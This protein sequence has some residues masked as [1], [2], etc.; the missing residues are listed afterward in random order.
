MNPKSRCPPE[1]S[2]GLTGSTG[3][4]ATLLVVDDD[5]ELLGLE[6]RFLGGLGYHVL[7]AS[8]PKEAL[9]LAAIT[10]AIDLLLTDYSM[11]ETNGLELARL[12]RSV[13]PKAPVLMVSGSLEMLNGDA[14]GLERFETLAKPFTVLELVQKVRT[15]LDGVQSHPL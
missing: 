6:A 9:R 14:G 15:L 11:P 13:H 4:I 10:P 8:G 2:P 3:A 7:S 5:E 1:T 12:I